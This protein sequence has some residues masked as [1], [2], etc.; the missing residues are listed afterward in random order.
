MFLSLYFLE[1]FCN[2]IWE[3]GV[4]WQRD[5]GGCFVFC[6]PKHLS[7]NIGAEIKELYE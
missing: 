7:I 3:R 1:E 6:V 4:Y 2:E 5:F